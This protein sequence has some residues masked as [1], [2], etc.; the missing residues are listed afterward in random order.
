MAYIVPGGDCRSY[1]RQE[2][3]VVRRGRPV[4]SVGERFPDRGRVDGGEGGQD[5]GTVERLAGGSRRLGHFGG[6]QYEERRLAV[7]AADLLQARS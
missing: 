4:V 3:Q 7:S 6:Y 2:G 5:T 1:G